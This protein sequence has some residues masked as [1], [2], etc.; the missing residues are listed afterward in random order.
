MKLAFIS[1]FRFFSSFVLNKEV[2][3][4]MQWCFTRGVKLLAKKSGEADSRYS[5][6]KIITQWCPCKQEATLAS[7]EHREKNLSISVG[8]CTKD[9]VFSSKHVMSSIWLREFCF[10]SIQ[11]LARQFPYVGEHW[12]NDMTAHYLDSY[13]LSVDH[14]EKTT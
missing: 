12:N 13:F 10:L 11:I 1:T 3:I 4:S 14:W 5:G 6:E 2:Y 9:P 8:I 7:Q